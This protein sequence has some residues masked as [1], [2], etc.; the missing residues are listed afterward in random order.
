MGSFVS[1]GCSD[2]LQRSR[3]AGRP[4]EGLAKDGLCLGALGKTGECGMAH[5]HPP[6]N[7]SQSTGQVLPE[8]E[9]LPILDSACQP[10]VD[11][12]SEPPGEQSS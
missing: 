3:R 6:S 2:K 1:H 8:E 9:E 11:F 4:Q 10:C 7:L 12:P 5:T